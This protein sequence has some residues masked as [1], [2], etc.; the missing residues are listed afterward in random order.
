MTRFKFQFPFLAGFVLAAA[1]F[2]ILAATHRPN[3]YDVRKSTAEVEQVHGIYVFTDCKPV[4][5]YEYIGKVEAFWI[6]KDDYE[7]VRDEVIRLVKKKQKAANAVIL[8]FSGSSFTGD[9]IKIA[10]PKN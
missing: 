2:L 8:H 1:C 3:L 7:T 10:E 9:A 5:E 4:M 6:A